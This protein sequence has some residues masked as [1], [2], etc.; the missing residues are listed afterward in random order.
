M[1]TALLIVT[2]F[3]EEG[4][5]RSDRGEKVGRLLK[6]SDKHRNNGEIVMTRQ[7]HRKRKI[8]PQFSTAEK[9]RQKSAKVEINNIKVQHYHF[10]RR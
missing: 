6:Q 3:G 10:G 8:G 2:R 1:D 5:R 9:P 7:K 4:G